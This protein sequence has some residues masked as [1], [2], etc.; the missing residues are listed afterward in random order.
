MTFEDGPIDGVVVRPVRRFEDERGWLVELFRQDELDAAEF[1]VMA[2][3]SQTLP[4][5]SRG[6]HEHRRQ[7]DLFLFMGPG[8]FKVYLWDARADSSTYRRRMV[9]TVGES[10]PQ[11]ILIPPGG[12]H[13]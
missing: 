9:L 12:V 10:N 11:S 1:P 13:G 4:G 6:P 5:A 7:T 2:Y 3:V 8:D